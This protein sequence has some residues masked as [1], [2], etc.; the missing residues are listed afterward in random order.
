MYFQ[1]VSK[2]WIRPDEQNLGAGAS[3]CGAPNMQK[4]SNVQLLQENN[5]ANFRIVAIRLYV[6]I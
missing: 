1:D 2:T 6:K 4:L 3:N 5:K